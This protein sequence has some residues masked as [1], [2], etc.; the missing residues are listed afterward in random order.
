LLL[1]IINVILK[2]INSAQSR[3]IGFIYIPVTIGNIFILTIFIIIEKIFYK[4]IP[5]EL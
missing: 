5:K 1:Q 4:I 3:I 2:T